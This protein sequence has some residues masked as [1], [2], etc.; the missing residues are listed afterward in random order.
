MLMIIGTMEIVNV[1]IIFL[2]NLE[3]LKIKK[4]TLQLPKFLMS[5]YQY[6]G[7]KE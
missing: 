4:I 6:Y 7:L 2:L 5:L 3:M 1:D